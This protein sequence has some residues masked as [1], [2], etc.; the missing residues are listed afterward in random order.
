[1]PP[2]NS[3]ETFEG[4]DFAREERAL[5]VGAENKDAAVVFELVTRRLMENAG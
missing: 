1:M 5:F 2:N 4:Y 3:F